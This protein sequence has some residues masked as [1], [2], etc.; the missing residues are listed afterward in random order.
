MILHLDFNYIN[1]V[2]VH[3]MTLTYFILAWNK[4][5]NEVKA[6]AYFQIFLKASYTDLHVD[7]YILMMTVLVMLA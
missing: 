1:Y 3:V 7:Y 6:A 4:F 2:C 5:P